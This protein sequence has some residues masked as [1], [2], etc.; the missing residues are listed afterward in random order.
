MLGALSC[1]F[2]VDIGELGIDFGGGG[3]EFG[4]GGIEFD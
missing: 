1:L 2:V 3:I 4:G